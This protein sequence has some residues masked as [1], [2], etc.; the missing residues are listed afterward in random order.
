MDKSVARD[1]LCVINAYYRGSVCDIVEIIGE[2]KTRPEIRSV[3]G[4]RLERALRATPSDRRSMLRHDLPRIV[5]PWSVLQCRSVATIRYNPRE[6]GG[7]LSCRTAWGSFLSA[8]A[9]RRPP[10]K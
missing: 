1:G 2:T 5:D 3:R 7:V 4:E 9:G 8:F 6:K 10:A